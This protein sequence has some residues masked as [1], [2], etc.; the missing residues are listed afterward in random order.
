MGNLSLKHL[1]VVLALWPVLMKPAYAD[2]VS[3]TILVDN[4]GRVDWSHSGNNLIAFDRMG[5]D[6]YFD[7]WTM[8]PDASG[9][10][11]LTCRATQL[12]QRHIG[13]PAWHPSG[14]LIVFQAQKGGVP[15]LVDTECTPGAGVLNDLWLMTADGT[16]YWKLHT[17]SDEVSR[18][19][20]GVL[21]PHFSH[22]GKH[23]IW[24]E[25]VRA[26]GRAFGEWVMKL[27]DFRITALGP[28][29]SNIR[30][31]NP[32]PVS[33]FYETHGFSPNDR[34]FLFTGNQH[35][36]LEIYEYDLLTSQLRRLTQDLTIW[37]EHAHYN[38][39]GSKIVWMSS[40]G[41]QIYNRLKSELWLMDRSGL[42][43]TQITY[44]NFPGHPHYLNSEAIVAADSAWS[45]DGR[46]IV[47]TL[48]DSD[49]NSQERDKGKIAIV[50]FN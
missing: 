15:K 3:T 50:S 33:A 14:A 4:G 6:G 45:P 35:G 36:G 13:N 27:A 19:S 31:I 21:H 26:N 28:Q 37:D 48:I 38:P 10:R 42:N 9:Q 41:L 49:P 12:P 11:C 20:Q 47:V 16:R 44:F 2:G 5:L 8:R 22:D 39:S 30:P 25:R 7:I 24:S 29:L 18:D 43:K 23:L 34:Y 17:V 32:S 46:H 40:K 1:F